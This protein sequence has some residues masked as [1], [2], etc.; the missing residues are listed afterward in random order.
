MLVLPRGEV[1]QSTASVYGRFDERAGAEGFADR[2]ARLEGALAGATRARDLAQLPPNDLASSPLAAEL[3]AAG[4]V[5]RRR[6]RRRPRAST[7]CS[8]TAATRSPPGV[9][10]GAVGAPG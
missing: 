5:P 4:R 6:D 3:A 8:T 10:S 7:G 2:V 9:R 1:K